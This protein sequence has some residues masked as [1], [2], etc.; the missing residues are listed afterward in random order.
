[1]ANFS[2]IN[3]ELNRIAKFVNSKA[4]EVIEHKK[5]VF[6]LLDLINNK[7]FQN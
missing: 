3:K 5:R 1:M 6:F 7:N 2:E 4:K